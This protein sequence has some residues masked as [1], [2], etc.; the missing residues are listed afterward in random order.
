MLIR[1]EH[2]HSCIAWMMVICGTAVA[3]AATLG[4]EGHGKGGIT[5]HISATI[6]IPVL[7]DCL[8][9]LWRFTLFLFNG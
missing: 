6:V 5:D 7:C 3:V 4:I 8:T 1:G 2:E 9:L